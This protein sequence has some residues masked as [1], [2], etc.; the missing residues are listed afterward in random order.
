MHIT[1]KLHLLYMLREIMT[2]YD[3][4]IEKITFIAYHNIKI[5]NT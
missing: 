3:D 2:F 4:A 1:F 5:Y